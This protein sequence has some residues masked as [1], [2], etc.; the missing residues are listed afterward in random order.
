MEIEKITLNAENGAILESVLDSFYE[1]GFI[2]DGPSPKISK[3]EKKWTFSFYPMEVKDAF[4][5]GNKYG[6]KYNELK[7][8]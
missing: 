4:N 8:S 7:K 5:L 2:Y 3:G 6:Q 1:D